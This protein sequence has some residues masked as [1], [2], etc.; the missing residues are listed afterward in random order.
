MNKIL[1]EFK[2]IKTERNKFIDETNRKGEIL[3]SQAKNK[4]DSMKNSNK[5]M[6]NKKLD[7]KYEYLETIKIHLKKA[8]NLKEE[9][10]S[11]NAFFNKSFQDLILFLDIKIKEILNKNNENMDEEEENENFQDIIKLAQLTKMFAEE[12]MDIIK[13]DSNP[14]KQN[15]LMQLKENLN[16]INN[17][18]SPNIITNNNIKN[19]SIIDKLSKVLNHISDY[20]IFIYNDINSIN[21]NNNNDINPYI[22]NY[23]LNS[24]F[25]NNLNINNNINNSKIWKL[26]IT[27]NN[28]QEITFTQSNFKTEINKKIKKYPKNYSIKIYIEKVNNAEKIIKLIKYIL[29]YIKN[30][31]MNYYVITNNL[32]CKK[33]GYYYFQIFGI[34]KRKKKIIQK[35]KNL[36]DNIN[37]KTLYNNINVLI[38]VSL[39]DDIDILLKNKF[40]KLLKNEFLKLNDK[41]EENNSIININDLINL[42]KNNIHY[43]FDEDFITKYLNLDNIFFEK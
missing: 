37:N 7:K 35:I 21:F 20:I 11:Y 39:Y 15:I 17:N 29:S 38:K 5:N 30:K 12:N 26:I 27:K 9:I 13:S 41:K 42:V 24:I 4:F 19:D 28:N 36:I 2:R 18:L 10:Y 43:N 33:V 23:L 22:S 8:I 32:K 31:I 1:E 6:N 25:I 3:L 34:G 14:Q 16:I 40:F